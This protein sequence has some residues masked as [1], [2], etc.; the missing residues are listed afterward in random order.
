MTTE[1]G[2]VLV[3]VFFFIFMLCTVMGIPFYIY[4]KLD[5]QP[6]D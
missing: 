1:L 6:R 2:L 4:N 3:T 5:K